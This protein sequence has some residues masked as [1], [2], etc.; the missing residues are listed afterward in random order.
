MIKKID[1]YSVHLS[2]RILLFL[3][4]DSNRT[5]ESVNCKNTKTVDSDFTALNSNLSIHRSIQTP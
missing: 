5:V 2:R 4:Q 3:D 1:L